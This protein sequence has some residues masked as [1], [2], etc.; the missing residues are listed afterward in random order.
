MNM[1]GNK[2]LNTRSSREEKWDLTFTLRASILF[3]LFVILVHYFHNVKIPNYW[4]HT[5]DSDSVGHMYF[6][7]IQHVVL[8]CCQD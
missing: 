3:K 4:T 6:L 1:E 7:N 8:L 2:I 5:G